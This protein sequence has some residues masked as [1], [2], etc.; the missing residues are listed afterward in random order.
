M[1]TTSR[2]ETSP[3]LSQ[4]LTTGEGRREGGRK[5]GGE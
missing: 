2:G 4:G 5:G 3:T 1:W